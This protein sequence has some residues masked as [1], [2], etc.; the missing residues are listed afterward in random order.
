MTALHLKGT[1]GD[2]FIRNKM[3]VTDN[4]ACSDALNW[5][6]KLTSFLEK[7]SQRENNSLKGNRIKNKTSS[8]PSPN[9]MVLLKTYS[10]SSS[11]SRR[12]RKLE[13]QKFSISEFDVY[14][15]KYSIQE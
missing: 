2:S 14:T 15:R 1:V 3:V 6:V 11:I 5:H 9:L 7:K 8:S 12:F 10:F 13:T 4:S